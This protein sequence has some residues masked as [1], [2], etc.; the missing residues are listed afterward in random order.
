MDHWA[1]P[2]ETPGAR[3]HGAVMN[4]L[5]C[6]TTMAATYT[7]PSAI[8]CCAYCGAGICFDHARILALP[9]QPV[10]VVLR[11][12]RGARRVMCATCYAASDADG[13]SAGTLIAI[14]PAD[15]NGSASKRGVAAFAL[16]LTGWASSPGGRG[17]G[18][19][20]RRWAFR[21]RRL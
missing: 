1:L 16:A 18:A 8:G 6:A 14:A 4:C 5:E 12:E 21:W 9:G 13:A 17:F 15:Q 2:K 10:G 19:S 3:E 11:A 7:A 20:R